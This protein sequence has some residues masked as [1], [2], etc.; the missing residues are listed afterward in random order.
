MN[1]DSPTEAVE[2]EDELM[3]AA[4]GPEQLQPA[5]E[6]PRDPEEVS[7]HLGTEEAV[8]STP[9]TSVP[10]SH[11][12]SRRSSIQVDEGRGGTLTTNFGPMRDE[13]SRPNPYPFTAS[14]PPLPRPPES[15]SA[16]FFE[17]VS[18]DDDNSRRSAWT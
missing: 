2:S 9:T 3:A 7:T 16:N 17:V 11:L 14:L 6:Q 1:D 10:P 5:F 13:S 15:S 4:P 12:P 18:F 8:G